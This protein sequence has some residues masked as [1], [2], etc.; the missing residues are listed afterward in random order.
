MRSLY[1]KLIFNF[2]RG[3]FWAALCKWWA[4]VVSR[5]KLF[6]TAA[7]N[8]S[9][10]ANITIIAVASVLI[11]LCGVFVV[12]KIKKVEMKE[13]GAFMLKLLF[14]LLW[15]VLIMFIICLAVI[16]VTHAWA[17]IVRAVLGAFGA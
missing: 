2:I 17:L 10:E 9:T 6:Y 1:P 5:C 13:V 16:I 15:V 3:P 4:V 8:N 12:Q 11:I 7:T 14:C